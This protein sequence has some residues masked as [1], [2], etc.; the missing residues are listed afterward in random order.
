MLGTELGCVPSPA[1][2]LRDVSVLSISC[3]VP[4]GTKG[5]PLGLYGDYITPRR[6]KVTYST[7]KFKGSPL[8]L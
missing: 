7:T 3:P 1:L 8:G 5:S 6:L 2:D 4:R